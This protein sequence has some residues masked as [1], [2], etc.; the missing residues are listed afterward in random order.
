MVY[1]SLRLPGVGDE[2]RGGGGEAKFRLGRRLAFSAR[3]FC[4]RR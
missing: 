2:R 1:H 4:F 3:L